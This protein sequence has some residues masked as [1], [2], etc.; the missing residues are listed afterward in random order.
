MS[1]A[2]IPPGGI[3]ACPE[4]FDFAQDEL[5]RRVVLAGRWGHQSSEFDVRVSMFDAFL[6]QA[7]VAGFRRATGAGPELLAAQGSI[8]ALRQA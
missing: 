1:K 7:A 4:P 5:R 6:D 2:T 8:Q 3:S